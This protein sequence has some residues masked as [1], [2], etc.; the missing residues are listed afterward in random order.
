MWVLPTRPRGAALLPFRC[1]SFLH[2]R[3]CVGCPPP[4]PLSSSEIRTVGALRQQLQLQTSGG[5]LPAVLRGQGAVGQQGTTCQPCSSPPL[6]HLFSPKRPDKAV[7]CQKMVLIVALPIWG[8]SLQCEQHIL[9]GWVLGEP[10]GMGCC[11]FLPAPTRQQLSGHRGDYYFLL[12]KGG[13]LGFFLP[14]F[15][16]FS[17]GFQRSP[18]SPD[19][20]DSVSRWASTG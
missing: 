5:A 9:Q 16:V 4:S 10:R 20:V 2:R 19:N 1:H 3:I 6:S 13:R 18:R 11:S 7:N 15:L 14:D 17:Q 8:G 12:C